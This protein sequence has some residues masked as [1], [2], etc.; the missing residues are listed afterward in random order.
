VSEA[1]AIERFVSELAAK[2]PGGTLRTG[3][4]LREVR[5]HLEE[6]AR[7]LRVEGMSEADAELEAVRRFGCVDELAIRFSEEAPLQPENEPMI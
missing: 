5:A 2:L 4:V 7:S 6:A 1:P 3:R